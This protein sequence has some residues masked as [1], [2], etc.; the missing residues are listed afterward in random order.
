MI[1]TK[2]QFIAGKSDAGGY[3][4]AQLRAIGLEM[5]AKGWPKSGWP[6]RLIGRNVTDEQ[7]A[8]FLSLR[9]KNKK[10]EPLIETAPMFHR[11]SS[12]ELLDWL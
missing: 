8:A 11:D 10:R 12:L 6:S 7:Y 1:L 2:E 5:P 3:N 4:I 9:G